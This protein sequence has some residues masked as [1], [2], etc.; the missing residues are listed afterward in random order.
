MTANVAPSV[1]A[2]KILETNAMTIKRHSLRAVTIV[3]C[4]AGD[5][6]SR[7]NGLIIFVRR[8]DARVREL[9]IEEI[10]TIIVL[11]AYRRMRRT[12]SAAIKLGRDISKICM[13]RALC[14]IALKST[15]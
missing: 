3:S 2:S 10:E 4:A 8:C 9:F 14:R 13:D 11:N 6:P 1:K 12:S 7:I 15:I 5:F